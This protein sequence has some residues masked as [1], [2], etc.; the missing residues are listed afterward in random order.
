MQNRCPNALFR[1]KSDQAER[2]ILS[3]YELIHEFLFDCQVRELSNQT[4]HNYEKQLNKFRHFVR[5]NFRV[6]EFEE[7][8]PI[9]VK[10]YIASLQERECKPAYINDLLKAVKCLCAY[11]QREGYSEEVLTKR[12]RNVKQPKV[13]IHTFSS[14]EIMWMVKYYNGNDYISVR[15]KMIIM[16]FFDTGIRLSELINMKLEQIQ[17]SYFIIYGKGR[18]ERVVPKNAAVGKFLYKYL[19]A[20]DKYFVGKRYEEEYVFLAGITENL[21]VQLLDKLL[22]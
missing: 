18:K 1:L 11:A 7:L 10:Q 16:I 15:N 20:R 13:L 5:E 9:H 19:A 22:V 14:K 3:L 6:I 4:I 2:G 8:K 21:N 17:D 12:I